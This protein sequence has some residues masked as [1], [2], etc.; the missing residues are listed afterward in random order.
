M[1]TRKTLII[2]SGLIVI[3]LFALTS[4]IS[5]NFGMNYGVENAELIREQRAGESK[6]KKY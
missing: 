6:K 5:Y 4:Y 1:N 2:I 3:A